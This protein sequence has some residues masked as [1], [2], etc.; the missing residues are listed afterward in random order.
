MIEEH[1]TVSGKVFYT[2]DLGSGYMH[3]N[4]EL[5][6][7]FERQEIV[8]V[9]Y[10]ALHEQHSCYGQITIESSQGLRV[11]LDDLIESGL[12]QEYME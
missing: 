4:I 3:K 2:S 8:N 7:E 12:L 10:K 5:V 11:I 6:K 9:M 1:K